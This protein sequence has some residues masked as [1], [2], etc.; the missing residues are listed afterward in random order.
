MMETPG[1]LLEQLIDDVDAF[2]ER[3]HPWSYKFR[4][5]REMAAGAAYAK[6]LEGEDE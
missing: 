6:L 1:E 2:G 3:G 4:E 5:A